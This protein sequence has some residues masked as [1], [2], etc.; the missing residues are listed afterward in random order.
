MR[1][2]KS[3]IQGRFE[4]SLDETDEKTIMYEKNTNKKTNKYVCSF[5]VILNS[6]FSTLFDIIE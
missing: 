5:V 1:Y 3:K 6:F 2:R 4:G